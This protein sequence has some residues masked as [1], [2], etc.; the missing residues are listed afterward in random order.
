MKRI[1]ELRPFINIALII[2]GATILLRWLYPKREMIYAVIALFFSAFIIAYVLNPVV[3]TLTQRRLSRSVAVL[4]IFGLFFGILA[5][6]ITS[7]VPSI[8]AEIQDLVEFLPTYTVRLQ[9][10]IQSLQ[11]QYDRFNLPES[12]R[13]VIDE[14]ISDAEGY[15]IS[16]FD[17]IT[18]RIVA[19]FQY[20]LVLLLLPLLVFYFLRDFNL[21]KDKIRDA[22]PSSYRH[23]V[24]L[25]VKEMDTTLGAYIRGILLISFLVGSMVYLGLLFLR[26]EFALVLAIVSGITN[27]I[28]YFGP[29][30]GSVPAIFIALLDSPLL[31]LKVLL[32]IFV[33]Q[34]IES[35]LISPP[36]LGKTLGIHPLLILFALILGGRLAGL[37]GLLLAVPIMAMLRIVYKH[38]SR[39]YFTT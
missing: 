35:Q 16:A 6:L 17:D 21:F 15:L 25:L 10:F 33:V 30:I 31:A 23:K 39:W 26:V 22:I 9:D 3:T 27:L 18:E 2:F 28:P 14:G 34:Q 12:V 1:G 4:I 20:I 7:L 38:I 36:I 8:V 29:I 5:L 11:S 32:L 24:S 13:V 19:L 37:L